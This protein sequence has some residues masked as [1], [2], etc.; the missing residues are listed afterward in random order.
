MNFRPKAF[1]AV[2]EVGSECE[3]CVIVHGWLHVDGQWVLHAWGET[4]EA[5]YDL[6][7]SREPI[8]KEEYY[9]RLGV[10]EERLRRYDRIAFFTLLGD[11][12]HFGPYDK[13]FFFAETSATDPLLRASG[14]QA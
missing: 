9:Q 10:T 12:R 4:A 14:G 6:T 8:K 11:H 3:E 7:E 1:E 5:V 13:E 2:I